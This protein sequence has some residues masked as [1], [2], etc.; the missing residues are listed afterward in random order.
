MECL[1]GLRTCCVVVNVVVGG[2][3][4]MDIRF[5]KIRRLVFLAAPDVVD[6]FSLPS[7]EGGTAEVE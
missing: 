1:L 3:T 7:N 4:E 5:G 2:L 6:M